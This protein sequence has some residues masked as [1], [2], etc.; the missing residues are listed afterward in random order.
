LLNYILFSIAPTL[1]D[2]LVAVV[3]FVVQF[4]AWFGLIVF[5]TMILYIGKCSFVK[6]KVS[7]SCLS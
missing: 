4:N 2:I 5:V 1:V 6:L 3:Y 7:R